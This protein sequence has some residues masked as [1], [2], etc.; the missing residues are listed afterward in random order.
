MG[1]LHATNAIYY[2]YLD[3]V[4]VIVM[5]ATGPMDIARRRPNIDWIHTTVLQ[6]DVVRQYVK[7]DRQPYGTADVIDS[8]ARGYR[9]ATQEPA[10]PVY[11]CYDAGFQEDPLKANLP[12]RNPIRPAPAAGCTPT[13]WSSSAWPSGWSRRETP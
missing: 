6:S 5:G 3:R 8:F 2:A 4:P 1:L 7:W 13:Q 10:G 12:C 9:V 11:L